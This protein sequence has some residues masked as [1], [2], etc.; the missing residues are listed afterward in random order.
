MPR[1]NERVAVLCAL[2]L[3]QPAVAAENEAARDPE[4][5]SVSVLAEAFQPRGGND[6]IPFTRY[7]GSLFGLHRDNYFNPRDFYPPFFNG[8]GVSSGDIRSRRLAG[9]GGGQR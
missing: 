3:L 9:R 8:S 2:F 4:G 5:R 1:I 7:D 6:E